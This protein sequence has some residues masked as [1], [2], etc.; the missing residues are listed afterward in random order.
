MCVIAISCLTLYLSLCLS[1][2]VCI[3]SSATQLLWLLL[4]CLKLIFVYLCVSVTIA[5]HVFSFLTFSVLCTVLSYS[6]LTRSVYR[7]DLYEPLISSL[8]ACSTL[9]TVLLLGMTREFTKPLFF[10]LFGQH[11]SYKQ[12]FIPGNNTSNTGIFVCRPITVM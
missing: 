5:I 3:F 6:S 1:P 11:F 8:R 7:E 4:S 10:E 12:L 2:C 9:S